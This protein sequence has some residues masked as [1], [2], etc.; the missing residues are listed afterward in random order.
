M[1][2]YLT[3][4]TARSSEGHRLLAHEAD[5]APSTAPRADLAGAASCEVRLG[6]GTVVTE[7]GRHELC[8]A[9][10]TGVSSSDSVR[11]APAPRIREQ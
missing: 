2:G 8:P 7:D 9:C 6:G 11:N 10:Q 3:G 5:H 4:F 1:D